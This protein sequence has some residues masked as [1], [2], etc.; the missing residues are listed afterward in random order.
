ML[1]ATIPEE[2]M[3]EFELTRLNV[4]VATTP[5]VVFVSSIEFVDD[6]LE[7]VFV[8]FEA[9]RSDAEI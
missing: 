2:A 7:R 8:V 3:T 9:S 1:V 6:A 5:F 4:V